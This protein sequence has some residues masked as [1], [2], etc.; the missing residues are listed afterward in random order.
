MVSP[1]HTSR[2]RTYKAAMVKASITLCRQ[3]DRGV[4]GDTPILSLRSR[5]EG[6]LSSGRELLHPDA[7]IM[8]PPSQRPASVRMN[9]STTLKRATTLASRRGPIIQCQATGPANPP[10]PPD[11][12]TLDADVSRY[13][14]FTRWIHRGPTG[15][16]THCLVTLL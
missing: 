11:I 7:H 15:Q 2:I 8:G 1:T 16:L 9:P 4:R 5:A 12:H 13:N 14:G 10:S 3:D 6:L